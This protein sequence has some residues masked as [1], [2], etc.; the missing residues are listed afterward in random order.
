MR[1]QGLWTNPTP[2]HPAQLA[3]D[4]SPKGYCSGNVE[5]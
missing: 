2:D 4:R 3:W 1:A 5:V